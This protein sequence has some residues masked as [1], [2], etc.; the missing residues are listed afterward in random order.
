MAYAIKMNRF[1]LIVALIILSLVILITTLLYRYYTLKH[2]FPSEEEIQTFFEKDSDKYVESLSS[3]DLEARWA[4]NKNEYIQ[5]SKKSI[6][7]WILDNKKVIIKG[8]KKANKLLATLK[9]KFD[10][11]PALTLQKLL[12]L[13]WRIVK[14]KGTYEGGLPH[15]RASYI[16][17][18]ERQIPNTEKEQEQEQEQEQEFDKL[19]STLIHEKVHILQRLYPKTVEGF[20]KAFNYEIEEIKEEVNP[21]QRANP[22]TNKTVYTMKGKRYSWLYRQHPVSITDGQL[23]P[24]KLGYEHPYEHM[25]YAIQNSL[26]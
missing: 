26:M 15:T 8:C 11:L 7:P 16:F 10:W 4:A 5:T 20:L 18:N 17:I 3:L 1:L 2:Q 13:P 9:N 24:D 19:V 25:A 14:T 21:N 6:S 12:S 22:D 23:V